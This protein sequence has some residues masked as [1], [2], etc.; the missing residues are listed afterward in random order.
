M[1]PLKSHFTQDTS[2]ECLD[3]FPTIS[4]DLLLAHAPA[5]YDFR[6]RSDIYFPYLGTS[7][8]VP[9]TPLYEYFPVGFKTLQRFLGEQG[10]DVKIVNLSTVL[11]RY[12]EVDLKEMFQ[13][14]DVKLFGL[15]LHWMVHV[16]GSL[17]IAELFKSV[18]PDVPVI[19]GGISSTYYAEQLIQYPFI[20][21]VMRGY[22][23]H[24]P[25]QSLLEK[26]KSGESLDK[27]PNLLW[28]KSG[29]IVNN[30]FDFLPDTYSCGIDWTKLP[31]TENR[32]GLPIM[33]VLSTQNAGCA[34][35]CGWCGGSRDA[36]RRI[37]K[38]HK[39]MAR[40]PLAEVGYEF[41]TMK[42]IK[43]QDR[44][45][46]YSIGSYNEPKDRMKFFIDRVAESN[47]KS[48]SYE[49]FHLTSDEI[50]DDMVRA[51]KRTIITLSP[52]SH[53]MRIAKLSGRG[54]YSPTQMENWIRKALDKGVFEIDVWYFIGMPEQ[55]ENCVLENVEYCKRLLKLFKGERVV[56]LLC[57][58]IP[59]LDPAS[60]FF[61]EPQK[62]G[63]RVFY[64]TVEEHRRG[65]EHA[66]IINRIN[67]ETLQLS[68]KDL[69]RVGFNA[70]R[71]LTEIKGDLGVLPSGIVQ[72]VIEKI[73]DA[74]KWIGIVHE[75]DCIS[76]PKVRLRELGQISDE[77]K[78]RN[79][80]IFFSGVANQAFPVNR[81]IGGRWFDEFLYDEAVFESLRMRKKAA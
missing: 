14:L 48:V 59:F 24:L 31:K 54:V 9:I 47:L 41:D 62:H 38:K 36:F 81:E 29:E 74:L 22:D 4:A 56:P 71:R 12:P 57:P 35:N 50:L 7:G 55:D 27:I 72:S 11:L 45:H 37:Y 44:Y 64:R 15:D 53:D 8:D 3:R 65:M 33:E 66:S 69:V 10:H 68:R 52:E 73:D 30:S 1:L 2:S 67:Y 26:L 16:Q 42:R 20:D 77:I 79:D 75:I 70:V 78:K 60:T 32:S 39:A 49:Q 58:M 80:S 63:Y 19:F 34:N 21:M 13:S 40:K 51:S 46:F 18:H 5:F 76:D 17:A 23:T 28:K 6:N 43:N 61:E 25:M